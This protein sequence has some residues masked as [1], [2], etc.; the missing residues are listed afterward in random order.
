MGYEN[1]GSPAVHLETE[2]DAYRVHVSLPLDRSSPSG[3]APW[4]VIWTPR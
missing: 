3:A 4:T 1:P 2:A